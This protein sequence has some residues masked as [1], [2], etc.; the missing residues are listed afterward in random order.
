[1]CCCGATAGVQTSTRAQ[2]SAG[3]GE[4]AGQPTITLSEGA[5]SA[6]CQAI[7]DAAASLPSKKKDAADHVKHA[8]EHL[9][10]GN[11]AFDM[12]TL[13]PAP[14]PGPKPGPKP[15]PGFDRT[16]DEYKNAWKEAT[17]SLKK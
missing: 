10:R 17:D 8:L 16:I 14:G 6:V 9:A 11:V 13:P 1:M 5:Q 12:A 3:S 7:Q 2:A 15:G 4:I